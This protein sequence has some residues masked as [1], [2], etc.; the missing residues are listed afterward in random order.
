MTLGNSLGETVD[1]RKANAKQ[2]H[3]ENFDVSKLPAG[4]YLIRIKTEEV[5]ITK[6]LIVK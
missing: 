4:L 3:K 1:I 2:Q 6:Q 5:H